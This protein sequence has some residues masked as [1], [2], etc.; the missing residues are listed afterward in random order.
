MTTA[1]AA[2]PIAIADLRARFAGTVIGP[3]DPA[4]DEARSVIY[5]AAARPAVVIQ[6]A[7]A[8][9]VARAVDLART[10]GLE[11]AVRSGGHSG[12]GH[13][14]VDGG[15]VLDLSAMKGIE[16]DVDARTVW[17]ETGLTAGELSTACAP[18]GLVIGFGDTGSVG[19]GGI[20]T[21][22]GVG[23]LVR[24]YGLTIDNVLAADVVTADGKL[25]RAD[26]EHDPDLFWA[27]RG[28]GGNFGV[29]TRF[30][31]RLHELPSI[32]GGM[33]LLPASAAVIA[34]FIEAAG[35]APEELSVIANVMQAP[36]MPFVPTE[37][38][39]SLVIMALMAYAGETEPAQRALA[40]FRALA[41]PIADFLRPMPYAEMFPPET[42]GP[43]VFG[44]NRTLFM[45]HVDEAD[46]Q[47]MLDRIAE[48]VRTTDAQ[49]A[50]A[51]IRV[52]GGAM[53][54]VPADATAFAHRQSPIMV[55]VA[56]VV[57]SLEDI[58]AH[59]SWLEAFAAALNQGDDGKYV[60]FVV[61]ED[62][63]AIHH[64]YPGAM[65]DRLAAIKARYDPTNLFRRNQNIPPAASAGG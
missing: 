39:G 24:K 31:Y 23:F 25:V 63:T 60:N 22:G 12:A 19:I 26:A 15:I 37:L 3:D 2:L 16:L 49:A 56:A 50:V 61:D 48:H 45:D 7:D 9:D 21:G 36:P 18:H 20:T 57:G 27:I 14:T 53:A 44:T 51:Q 54:R 11:L 46:A 29:V 10:S 42:G 5:S 58:P 30:R 13:G 6:A 59:A 8:A 47:L 55:N 65:W 64:A 34:G 43:H 28:G 40:P 4:Y 32:V 38:H 62:D 41:T 33:L 35:A 52:L 17:A 1:P